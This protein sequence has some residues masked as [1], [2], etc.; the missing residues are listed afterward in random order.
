[1]YRSIEAV[2]TSLL[3]TAFIT[4]AIIGITN[5]Q[6][7]IVSIEVDSSLN[8]AAEGCL[9]FI[10]YNISTN[11]Q[12]LFNKAYVQNLTLYYRKNILGED[13]SY[14][15][16]VITLY[17]YQLNKEPGS[18]NVEISHA[19]IYSTGNIKAVETL[20]HALATRGLMIEYNGNVVYVLI[21]V[22]AYAG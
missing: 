15:R 13:S 18:N 16:F 2:I 21:S 8:D 9:D 22:I 20:P 7:N 11:P 10:I 14:I 3:F 19:K 6:R 1:M 5:L 4:G 12:L 17:L